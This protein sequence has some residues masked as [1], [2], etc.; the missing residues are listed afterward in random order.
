MADGDR[1]VAVQHKHGERLANNV[2][3][4][5]DNTMLARNINVRLVQKAHNPRRSA[6]QK[7][8]IP[9]HQLANVNLV[10][11]VN[12]LNKAD[13]LNDSL[14]VNVGRQRHLH[15]N[16]VNITAAIKFID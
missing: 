6:R 3:A 9:R 4:A 5:D 2:A 11:R 13:A 1:G 7:L 10:K 15:Q 14:L 8:K 16:S 12:V